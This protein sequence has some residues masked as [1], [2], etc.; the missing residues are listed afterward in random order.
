MTVLCGLRYCAR[1]ITSINFWQPRCRMGPTANVC[2][3]ATTG[4]KMLLSFAN[5][6]ALRPSLVALFVASTLSAQAAER[7]ELEQFLPLNSGR[8]FNADTPQTAH[9]LLGLSDQELRPL[10]SQ[11]YANG[12]QITRYQQYHQGIPV[13]GETVTEL[14]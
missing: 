1:L 14:V 10:R 9:Q 13:W 11:Q 12:K 7:I 3:H 4:E 6:Y 2:F 8:A 5:K